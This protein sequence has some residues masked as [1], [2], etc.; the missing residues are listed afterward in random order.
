MTVKDFIYNQFSEKET[1]DELNF[2]SSEG[3]DFKERCLQSMEKTLPA[4]LELKDEL[5]NDIENDCNAIMK[6]CNDIPNN[7]I[8]NPKCIPSIYKM[9][10][11]TV[12]LYIQNF[13]NQR[14]SGMFLING[15]NSYPDLYLEHMDYACL[16]KGSK[17]LSK[18]LL[19][20]PYQSRWLTLPIRPNKVPD[21]LEL[22]AT[23][24]KQVSIMTHGPHVGLHFVVQ[25]MLNETFQIKNM[26][27]GF[28]N[29]QK[30][31]TYDIATEVDTRKY[32]FDH[33]HLISI[34]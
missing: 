6:V 25:W 30:Y 19:N 7:V 2:L 29:K 15:E 11:Q 3:I 9:S 23:S 27:L 1:Q 17:N 32:F 5:K 18:T 4:I 12:S 31:K 20:H 14:T 26:F 16:P 22:K 24:Q 10:S 34:L 28:L 13:L 33:K 21:G 8:R